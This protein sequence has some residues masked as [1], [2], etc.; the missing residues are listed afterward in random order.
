[1]FRRA[2]LASFDCEARMRIQPGA[3]VQ[4]EASCV[5]ETDACAAWAESGECD[6]STW[7]YT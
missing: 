2:V 4:V 5:D 1:M 7:L 3:T 6:A